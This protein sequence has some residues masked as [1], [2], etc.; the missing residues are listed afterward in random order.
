MNIFKSLRQ[1]LAPMRRILWL[2]CRTLVYKNFKTLFRTT[3][4]Y[5][6]WKTQRETG[7]DADAQRRRL[8]RCRKSLT[9]YS[10]PDWS[11]FPALS[12]AALASAMSS[13]LSPSDS[14][15]VLAFGHSDYSRALGGV[16]LCIGIEQ[17]ALNAQGIDYIYIFPAIPSLVTLNEADSQKQLLGIAVNGQVLGHCTAPGLV[18][19][20]S[21]ATERK[22]C[23]I[24]LVLHA[25]MGHSIEFIT[26]LKSRLPISKAYF[27]VHDFYFACVSPHLMKN[28]ISFCD[29]PPPG[30]PECGSCA[31][32][33]FRSVHLSRLRALFDTFPSIVVAPSRFVL[34]YWESHSTFQVEHRIVHEHVV[35]QQRIRSPRKVRWPLRI[36]FL[37]AVAYHK[38]WN[39][40]ATLAERCAEDGRYTFYLFSQANPHHPNIAWCQVAVTNESRTAMIETLTDRGIDI[41]ILWSQCPETFSFT[42]YEA[43]SAGA[44]ILTTATSGNIADTLRRTDRGVVLKDEKDLIDMFQSGDILALYTEYCKAGA[45]QER[46]GHSSMTADLIP[47]TGDKGEH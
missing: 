4:G 21:D 32:G 45:Q 19:A 31:Y 37:G 1:K 30:S 14:R 25:L 26:G 2:R 15:L 22:R 18:K 6:R 36:G 16:Q 39:A 43:M 3:V 47:A 38:G 27:W 17:S 20:I 10:H 34:D 29:A 13:R 33:A 12:D 40:Y 23:S 7:V 9:A 35:V 11:T 24:T 44:Y 46:L 8:S 5:Q 28:D 42:L 41:V